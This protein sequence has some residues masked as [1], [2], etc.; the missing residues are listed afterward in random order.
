MYTSI[1][2]V[3]F[4]DLESIRYL[5]GSRMCYVAFC[6]NYWL[7]MFSICRFCVFVVKLDI[8]ERK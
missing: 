1:F 6:C 8:N 2:K 3:T 5:D 7:Y 4:C